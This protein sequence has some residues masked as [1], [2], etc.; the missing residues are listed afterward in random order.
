MSQE[1]NEAIKIQELYKLKP[2]HFADLIRAVQLI[3]DPARGMSGI[4]REV[5]WKDFGIPD[6]VVENLKALGKEYRYAS[7]HI[8]PEIIW[9]K[10]TPQARIWFLENKEDLWQFEEFFPA[11]DED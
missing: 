8:P 6:D 9:S 5:D 4:Y 1:N 3:F 7:P 11:L 2:V 10:L